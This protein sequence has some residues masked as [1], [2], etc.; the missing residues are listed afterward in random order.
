MVNEDVDD[1][2]TLKQTSSTND[3][4]VVNRDADRNHE[5]LFDDD[6]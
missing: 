2:K 1:L 6:V 3:Y 4:D 5:N